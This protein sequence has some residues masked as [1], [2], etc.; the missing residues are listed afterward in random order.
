MSLGL[1]IRNNWGLW[2]GSRLQAYFRNLGI[3]HPDSMSGVI[4]VSYHRYLNKLDIQ[5]DAQLAELKDNKNRIIPDTLR[6]PPKI[7]N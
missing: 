6:S 4:L 3:N 5:L 2:S 7:K 1:W